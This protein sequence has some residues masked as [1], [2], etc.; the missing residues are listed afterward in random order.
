MQPVA[1]QFTQQLSATWQQW[2]RETHTHN[3]EP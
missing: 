3:I 2:R 1:S